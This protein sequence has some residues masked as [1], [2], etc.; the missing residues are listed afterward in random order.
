M[1]GGDGQLHFGINHF[2][3]GSYVQDTRVG[4]RLTDQAKVATF[5]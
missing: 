1:A 3:L 2:Q 4:I 5:S